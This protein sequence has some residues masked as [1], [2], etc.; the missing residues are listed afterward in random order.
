MENKKID[1]A[2]VRI[3]KN[4]KAYSEIISQKNT[5]A[6]KVIEESFKNQPKTKDEKVYELYD[7]FISDITTIY[8]D[9]GTKLVDLSPLIMKILW[10]QNK[11][12]TGN[13]YFELLMKLCEE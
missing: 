4:S 3:P 2:V 1:W 9:R 6:W 13:G 12:I 7:N 5:V 11:V 10:K 8:P